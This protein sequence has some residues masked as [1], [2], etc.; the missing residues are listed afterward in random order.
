MREIGKTIN[1]AKLSVEKLLG[2]PLL[3]KVNEGRGKITLYHGS[4]LTV[5]PSIF[6]VKLENGE[7]KTF[8]YSDVHSGNV[9]FVF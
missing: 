7:T 3:L 5:F 2:V 6:V 9:M 4:V 1:D 8:S